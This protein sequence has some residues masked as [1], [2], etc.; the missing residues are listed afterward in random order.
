MSQLTCSLEG[1]EKTFHRHPYHIKHSKTGKFYCCRDHRD[2]NQTAKIDRVCRRKSC[3]VKFKVSPYHY[4]EKGNFCSSK[5]SGIGLY[6]EGL[7]SVTKKLYPKTFD[8]RAKILKRKATEDLKDYYVKGVIQQK[9]S[10]NAKDISDDLI[11][12]K[13]KQLKLYRLNNEKRKR[14]AQIT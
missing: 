2:K 3:K 10:L 6:E 5:C 13:R 11:Q 14:S 12:L 7:L 8:L 1:C 4:N 9:I